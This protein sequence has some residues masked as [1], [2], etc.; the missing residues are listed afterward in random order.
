MFS[1]WMLMPVIWVAITVWSCYDGGGWRD[2]TS[3]VL[4]CT[5]PVFFMLA[6]RF[7]P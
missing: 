3:V 1:Y 2:L 5:I 4:F 7:L 6:T